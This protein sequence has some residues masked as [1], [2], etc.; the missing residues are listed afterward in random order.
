MDGPKSRQRRGPKGVKEQGDERNKG[1]KEA[2]GHLAPPTLLCTCG[3]RLI[4]D[5]NG[6]AQA[7]KGTVSVDG[8]H[9]IIVFGVHG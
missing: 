6:G 1:E 8:P 5:R 9:P 7:G 3:E 2:E 4:I